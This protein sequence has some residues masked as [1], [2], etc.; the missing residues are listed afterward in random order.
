MYL[1]IPLGFDIPVDSNSMFKLK[2][3]LYGLKK[4]PMLGLTG[5]QRQ[6]SGLD[7]HNVKLI[8][9]CSSSILKQVGGLYS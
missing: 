6:L 2:K 3:S 8:T 4:S 5:S 7:T 9:Q 1:E